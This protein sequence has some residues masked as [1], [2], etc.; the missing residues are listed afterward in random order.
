MIGAPQELHEAVAVQVAELVDPAQRPAQRGL[1]LAHEVVVGG[2]APGLGEQHQE[3]RRGIDRAVVAR[4]PDLGRAPAP[5]L[6]DDLAWLGVDARVVVL[7]L[8]VGEHAQRGVRE[9]GPEDERLQAR[10]DRCRGR[11]PS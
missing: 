3:E 5:Q 10:D 4:E 7:G 9:L 8:Q 11:R 2:P 6:V 1:E